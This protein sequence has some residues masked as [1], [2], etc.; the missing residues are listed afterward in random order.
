MGILALSDFQAP[1]T[2]NKIINLWFEIHSKS[3]SIKLE[4]KKSIQWLLRFMETNVEKFSNRTAVFRIFRA[5]EIPTQHKDKG[6]SIQ[7]FYTTESLST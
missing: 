4:N 1:N 3:K 2:R 6:F 5:M 7:K